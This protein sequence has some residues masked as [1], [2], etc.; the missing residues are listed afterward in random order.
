MKILK[1]KVDNV[2]L[3]SEKHAKKPFKTIVDVNVPMRDVSTMTPFEKYGEPYYM[4]CMKSGDVYHALCG[5]SI[6]RE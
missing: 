5:I 2:F 1:M 6:V 3:A 4:V